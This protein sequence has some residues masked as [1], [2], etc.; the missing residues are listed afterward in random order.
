[1]DVFVAFTALLLLLPL[2]LIIIFGLWLANRGEV[3]FIQARPGRHHKIFHIIKFKTMLDRKDEKG[4]LLPDEKRMSRFGYWIRKTSLDELPQLWNV[5]EGSM[6]LIGPR[7]LL[8]EYLPLY[9]REQKRRHEVRPG[10]TGWAQVNGRNGI[11]WEQK[12]AYDLWYVDKLSFWLDMKILF[13]TI[14]KVLKLEGI[15]AEGAATM[16][17][18]SGNSKVEPCLHR[19]CLPEGTSKS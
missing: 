11:S 7:P 12:F 5:L 15:S 16:P 8:E 3:F 9:S 4:V 18:F 6:S 14:L 2:F 19:I 1:M 17:K 10:I 13:M